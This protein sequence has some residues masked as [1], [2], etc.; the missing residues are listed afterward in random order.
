M[1][2]FTVK[3]WFF[4]GARVMAML[5]PA[6]QVYL[7]SLGGWVRRTAQTLMRYRAT[8]SSAPGEP[9]FAHPK[10]GALL[11]KHIY[12]SLD[13]ATRTVVVGAVAWPQKPD[14]WN[15][16][17]VHDHGFRGT[18]RMMNPGWRVFKLGRP[19]PVRVRTVWGDSP[20]GRDP[21]AAGVAAVFAPL[22]TQAQVDRAMG[23]RESLFGPEI[24]SRKVNYAPRPFMARAWGI[25]VDKHVPQK[26]A[27]EAF[28]SRRAG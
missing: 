6:E 23:L 26:F 14:G 27:R 5:A 16:P 19:G 10:R 21:V 24:Q 11:R 8:G 18:R 4:S 17:A 28:R 1:I 9:P 13:P 22:R 2:R 15:V 20:T 7:A 25:A 3:R 12:F